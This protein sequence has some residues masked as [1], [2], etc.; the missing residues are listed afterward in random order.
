MNKL[1]IKIISRL[2]NDFSLILVGF[3]IGVQFYNVNLGILIWLAGIV[4]FFISNEVKYKY[5]TFW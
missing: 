3:G 2:A 4:L 1:Q 5:D